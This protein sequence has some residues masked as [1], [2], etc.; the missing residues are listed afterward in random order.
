MLL[1][2]PKTTRPSAPQ[3]DAAGEHRDIEP[4]YAEVHKST[5]TP[6]DTNTNTITSNTS[7]ASP[8]LP[9][10]QASLKQHVPAENAHKAVANGGATSNVPALTTG[11]SS[12]APKTA[13]SSAATATAASKVIV[14]GDRSN[15]N[16]TNTSVKPEAPVKSAAATAASQ[17]VNV[18]SGSRCRIECECRVS[19]L[20]NNYLINPING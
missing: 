6:A 17:A 3:S 19:E 9:I 2:L 10:R 12:D 14:G 18:V 16:N 13:I 15:N 20:P 1:I 11:T 4:V 7:S 8:A 5:F